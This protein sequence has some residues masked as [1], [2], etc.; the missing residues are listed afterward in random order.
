MEKKRLNYIDIARAFAM[1]LIV[2]GHTVVYSKCLVG[3]YKLIYSFHVA[4]FFI[5]SGFTFKIRDNESFLCFFKKKFLRIMIPYFIWALLFL[6]PY[7]LFGR[8]FGGKLSTPPKFNLI[9]MLT[10]ILYGN[11]NMYALKQNT[12]LWFLPALFSTEII[13]YFIVKFVEKYQRKKF[14]IILP[15]L[16]ISFLSENY[17]NDIIIFPWGITTVLNIGIFFYIGYLLNEYNVIEKFSNNMKSISIILLLLGTVCCYLNYRDVAYVEYE[18]GNFAL[19]L[20]SGICMSLFVLFISKNIN[21]NKILQYLGKNTMGILIFH[22]ITILLF[23][24]KLG[25]ITQLLIESNALIEIILSILIVEISISLSL[26][27]TEII[28][29]NLPYMIGE[30]KKNL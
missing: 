30:S 16:I 10:N 28:R 21:D 20:I 18:Y 15:L 3:L 13:Y 22:K 26:I 9:I 8:T 7:I 19:A 23:Q 1:I 27:L 12:S 25:I 6:I 5:I 29:K 17:M 11:G 14:I 2:L 24:N 4:L